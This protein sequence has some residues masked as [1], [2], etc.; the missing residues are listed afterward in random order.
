MGYS[1]RENCIVK[2]RLVNEHCTLEFDGSSRDGKWSILGEII[3]CICGIGEIGRLMGLYT[4][5]EVS[6][7]MFLF[8]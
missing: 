8:S 7:V 5:I 1:V 6:K 3:I 4:K 2:P